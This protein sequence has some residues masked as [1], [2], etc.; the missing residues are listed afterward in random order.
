MNL[1]VVFSACGGIRTGK[2]LPALTILLS[3]LAY[4]ILGKGGLSYWAN[5]LFYP[6][7]NRLYG[8]TAYR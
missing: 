3:V 6:S 2:T 4:Y 8:L 7:W 1:I 5:W